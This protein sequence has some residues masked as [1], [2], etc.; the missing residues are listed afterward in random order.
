MGLKASNSILS[1]G[2]EVIK[3]RLLQPITHDRRRKAICKDKIRGFYCVQRAIFFPHEDILAV[4]Q[5]ALI[6]VHFLQ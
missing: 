1:A 2:R 4:G 3:K 5:A 6:L